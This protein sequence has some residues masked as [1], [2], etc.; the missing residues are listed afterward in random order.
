MNER[1]P[2]RPRPT[3]EIAQSGRPGPV[4]AAATRRRGAH[5]ECAALPCSQR[6]SQFVISHEF[7]AARVEAA[8]CRGA[9][10][11]PGGYGTNRRHSA[12]SRYGGEGMGRESLAVPPWHLAGPRCRYNPRG[13]KQ[14]KRWVERIGGALPRRRYGWGGWIGGTLPRC[15]YGPRGGYGT[16][17]RRS[18]E[19]P[20]R[21]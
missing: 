5:Q 14:R 4:D 15:R 19:A 17:R 7:F 18:A 10:T 13:V 12:E 6:M 20:L 11:A 16:N 2:S 3:F 1:R 21:L 9:A 8:L